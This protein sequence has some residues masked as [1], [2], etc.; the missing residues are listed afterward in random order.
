MCLVKPVRRPHIP[1]YGISE[2]RQNVQMVRKSVAPSMRAT[3]AGCILTVED[4]SI[5]IKWIV[6]MKYNNI[7]ARPQQKQQKLRRGDVM[8]LLMQS[9]QHP[10][11]SAFAIARYASA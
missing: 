3:S 9:N 7:I 1:S 10:A 2:A 8:N 5:E 11:W 6:S 4:T